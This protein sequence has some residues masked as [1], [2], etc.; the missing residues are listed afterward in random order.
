M[1]GGA[2]SMKGFRLLEHTADMGIEAEAETLAGLF[3]QAALGLRRVITEGEPQPSEGEVA[4]ELCGADLEELLVNWL[5]ELLYLFETRR[6]L[7]VC[8]HF[9]QLAPTR[10][11][12]RVGVE[13]IDPELQPVEREVKA[14]TYHQIR[15]KR[16]AQGWK[17]R[18][19]LDL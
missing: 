19:Y 8:C 13:I 9:E 14:V 4:L 15:V 17:A 16:T 2:G 11:R 5:T 3:E 12:V 1:R 18:L 10:L 6:W 7:P